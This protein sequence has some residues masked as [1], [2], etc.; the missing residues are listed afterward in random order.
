MGEMVEY[1]GIVTCS[2][3]MKRVIDIIYTLGQKP[4]GDSL[5]IHGESGTGKELVANAIHATGDRQSKPFLKLNCAAFPDTLIESE[6]FGYARGAFTG[7]SRNKAGYFKAAHD[8][9]LFLDEIAD[10]ALAQQVKL[11]RV[12]QEGQVT[13]LGS[14]ELVDVDVQVISASSKPLSSYVQSG[15]FRADLL[16]RLNT[17][18]LFLPALRDRPEDIPVL[19]EY[20]LRQRRL[21]HV[22]DY[23]F[24]AGA[25][26]LMQ[27]YS[28]PGNVRQLE[29]LIRGITRLKA[30][31]DA[32]ITRGEV[33][34][35]IKLTDTAGG[36]LVTRKLG[37]P[38]TGITKEEIML[39][40][41]KNE[42]NKARTARALGI[43]RTTLWDRMKLFNLLSD[44]V[45]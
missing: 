43:S 3:S 6:L 12:L 21:D 14:T 8:G 24:S 31:G 38:R 45:E 16:Y 35:R 41:E 13:P 44:A 19:V 11:L 25:L 5:Y 29:N 15:A 30:K 23:S 2:D 20:F 34:G 26:T 10:M 18:E 27:T 28:W 37:R 39:E 36:D 33:E 32:V 9:S 42:G 17:V 4:S 40:F 1:H 7:A 22:E